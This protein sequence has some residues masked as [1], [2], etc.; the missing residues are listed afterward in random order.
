V[1]A[2]AVPAL[3]FLHTWRKRRCHLADNPRSCMRHSGEWQHASHQRNAQKHFERI[4]INNIYQTLRNAQKLSFPESGESECVSVA[5]VCVCVCV[6]VT[7]G[8]TSSTCVELS[9][10]CGKRSGASQHLVDKVNKLC[11][12]SRLPLF[13]ASQKIGNSVG[14]PAERGGWEG[15]GG[16]RREGERKREIEGEGE[17]GREGERCGGWGE[18][19]RED[20]KGVSPARSGRHNHTAYLVETWG[21]AHGF[22]REHVLFSTRTEKQKIH[23]W[24]GVAALRHSVPVELCSLSTLYH[25]LAWHTICPPGP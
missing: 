8:S 14:V 4:P 18:S 15:V 25:V 10:E 2:C 7:R 17:G 1:A 5:C 19:E 6:C 20:N 11:T 13:V 21:G 3:P 22:V 9:Q 12:R 24:A 23:A 16:G